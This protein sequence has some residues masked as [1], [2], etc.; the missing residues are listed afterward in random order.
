M[1]SSLFYLS[2][3]TLLS[4]ELDAMTHGEWR[5]IPLLSA[6]PVQ[7]AMELF[8]LLHIPL[9]A[10]LLP[11]IASQVERIRSISLISISAFLIV[12]AALHLW[13]SSTPEYGFT[14]SLSNALIFSGAA[15]GGLYLIVSYR[16]ISL[17]KRNIR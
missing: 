15:L 17:L 12:H 5:L 8:V 10:V 7:T 4:H 1:K 14:S 3:A 6:L 11:L 13:F 9:F 16:D 2:F